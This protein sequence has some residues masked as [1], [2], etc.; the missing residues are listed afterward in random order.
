MD[1]DIVSWQQSNRYCAWMNRISTEVIFLMQ[2][3]LVDILSVSV[4]C[5]YFCCD[6]VL[7]PHKDE[8]LTAEKCREFSRIAHAQ[9]TL[10][11]M[12][13]VKMIIDTIFLVAYYSSVSQSMDLP[14][15]KGA[16]RFDKAD[17]TWAR[18]GCN[19]IFFDIYS[20]DWH[21]SEKIWFSPLRSSFTGPDCV[22]F[23]L[24]WQDVWLI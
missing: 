5:G 2:S 4:Y 24:Q 1:A 19:L 16:R 6:M 11:S 21:A 23:I 9:S 17:Y 13:P 12:F 10:S 14:L 3:T 7:W 20:G 8:P 22:Y 18:Y 15:C